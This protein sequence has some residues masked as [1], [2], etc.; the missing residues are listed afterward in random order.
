MTSN[1][2]SGADT[3]TASEIAKQSDEAGGSA[4][5]WRTAVVLGAAFAVLLAGCTSSH[6]SN[7]P[8]ASTTATTGAATPSS[9]ASVSATVPPTTSAVSTAAQV[10]AIRNAYIRFFNPATSVAESMALLQDGTAFRATLDQQAKSS[11]AKTA[12]VKVSKV[13]INSANKATVVYTLLLSGSPVLSNQMGFAVQ[14]GG[15]WKVSGLTFCGL[16]S[17]QGKPPAVCADPF[18]IS[19]PN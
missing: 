19:L 18:A 16:L 11:F 17:A 13:T 1:S 8:A 12:S 14:E 4:G 9:T 2:T 10:A 7:P 6:S 5:R 15:A 3:A